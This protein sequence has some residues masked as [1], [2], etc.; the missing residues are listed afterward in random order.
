[1]T[2][3]FMWLL[4]MAALPLFVVAGSRL[5]WSVEQLRRLAVLVSVALTFVSSLA[6]VYEPLQR[7]SVILPASVTTGL[8]VPLFRVDAFSSVLLPFAA[9]LWVLTVTATPRA[10]L[11]RDDI[12]RTALSTFITLCAFASAHPLV[13][14]VAWFFSSFLLVAALGANEHAHARRVV[15]VYLGVSCAAFLA[16]VTL[17]ALPSSNPLTKTAAVLLVVVAAMI[18]KGILPFHAWLPE[19]FERGRLGP[20]VMFSAPELGAYVTAVLVLPHALPWMLRAM[21]MCALVT[22]VYGALLAVAQK[23]ARRACGYLFVSQSALVMAGL[24][25]ASPH[26]LAGALLV[27]L[28]SGIGFAGLAR[29]VLVLEARRGRL[30]LL[31]FHGG[32]ERMPLLAVSFLVLGLCCTGFP[33]TLGF[34]GE[35]LLVDGTV[36]AFPVLGFAVVVAGALTGLAVLR[37]YFALFCGRKDEGVHLSLLTREALAFGLAAGL[38]IVTGLIPGPLVASRVRASEALFATVA[39]HAPTVKH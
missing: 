1:M 11:N 37:M 4:T 32:Y 23:D 22:A 15:I 18:R 38:L 21:A 19:V 10:R 9:L 14:T 27:W 8:A 3:G 5:S 39:A 29:C 7:V 6:L 30:S 36:H 12:T 13:L 33:G 26:S 24:D 20:A 16:G 31:T 34:I 28:S 25:C 2:D 35:E 17:L